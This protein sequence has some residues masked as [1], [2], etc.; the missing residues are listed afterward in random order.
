MLIQWKITSLDCYPKV[1]N[2]TNVI[3]NVTWECAGE[4]LID[5]KTYKS[6]MRG[7]IPLPFDASAPFKP[8]EQLEESEVLGWCFAAGLSQEIVQKSLKV[9]IE[10]QANPPIIR[11][12]LPWIVA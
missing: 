4:E 1:D 10:E 9:H 3:F 5:G 6:M 12:P 8:Y 2:D 7:Y 11:P